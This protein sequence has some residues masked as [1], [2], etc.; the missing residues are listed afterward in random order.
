[1]FR[2]RERGQ[3]VVAYDDNPYVEVVSSTPTSSLAALTQQTVTQPI[4]LIFALQLAVRN[5]TYPESVCVSKVRIEFYFCKKSTYIRHKQSYK[6][7]LLSYRG[8]FGMR[9]K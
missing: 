3:V 1:M 2:P 6:V 7:A 9:I 4:S 5:I 8:M